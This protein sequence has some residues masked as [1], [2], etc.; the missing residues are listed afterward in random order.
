MVERV[1]V[2]LPEDAFFEGRDG[3]RTGGVVQKSQLAEGFSGNIPL[4][5]GR[6]RIPGENFCAVK[7]ALT[8]NVQAV[9]LISFLNDIFVLRCV[10]FFH[11]ID[12]DFFFLVCQ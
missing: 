6:F 8:N 4:E 7:S 5:E 2:E 3:R 10:Y 12:N 9:A 11:S 1:T